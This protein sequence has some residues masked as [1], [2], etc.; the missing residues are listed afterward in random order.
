MTLTTCTVITNS[1]DN[2]IELTLLR[3][4]YVPGTIIRFPNVLIIFFFIKLCDFSTVI[5]ILK[6]SN[7]RHREVRV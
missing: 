6:M 2:N 5:C 3:T 1:D 4:Y 7:Q